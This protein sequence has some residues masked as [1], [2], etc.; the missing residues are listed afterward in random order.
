MAKIRRTPWSFSMAMVRTPMGPQP[1]TAAVS[2]GMGRAKWREWRA[3]ARG[4]K[5]VPS[6]KLRPAGRGRTLWAGRL[7]MSRKKPGSGPEL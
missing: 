2:P 1:Q 3:M 5:S 7:T 4:S 6:A